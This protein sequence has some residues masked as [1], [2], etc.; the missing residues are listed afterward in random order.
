MLVVVGLTT[1]LALPTLPNPALPALQTLPSPTLPPLPHTARL[2]KLDTD[3]K[4]VQQRWRSYRNIV[5]DGFFLNDSMLVLD[6]YYSDE[7]PDNEAFLNYFNY[8]SDGED[9][10]DKEYDQ[11]ELDTP[12]L[13]LPQTTSNFYQTIET[14]TEENEKI[15]LEINGLE[16]VRRN[17]TKTLYRTYRRAASSPH[18]WG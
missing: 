6:D 8:M 9:M 11:Q 14:K 13:K 3:I 18:W 4:E 12:A 17:K 10:A 7:E 15:P 2:L 5:K 1:S 16:Q